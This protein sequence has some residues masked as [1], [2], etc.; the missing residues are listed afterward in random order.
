[1]I[2]NRTRYFFSVI[3]GV[4]ILSFLTTYAAMDH[5]KKQE[6]RPEPQT[7]IP[8]P[9]TPPPVVELPPTNVIVIPPITIK[10]EKVNKPTFKTPN[11]KVASPLER[12]WVNCQPWRELV[13]GSGHVQECDLE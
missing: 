5:G 3:P 8:P 11:T 7:I 9:D 12:K 10:A 4:A 2:N 6:V 13:Q 1:M